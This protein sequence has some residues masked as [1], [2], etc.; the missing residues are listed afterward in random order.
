MIDLAEIAP[1]R[2]KNGAGWTR[3]IA[4]GPAGSSSDDFG[5]RLSVAEVEADAPF[6]AFAGVDRCIVVLQGPGMALYDGAGTLVQTL[7][8]W[9][10]GRSPVSG[11]C[12]RACLPARAVISTS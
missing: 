2:W 7:R 11:P 6:S 12:R 4:I 3:E 9:R 1:Q 10:H 5:W 8:H